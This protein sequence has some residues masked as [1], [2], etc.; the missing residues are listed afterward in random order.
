GISKDNAILVWGAAGVVGLFT[1]VTLLVTLISRR[2][3][4]LTL[5]LLYLAQLGCAALLFISAEAFQRETAGGHVKNLLKKAETLKAEGKLGELNLTLGMQYYALVGGRG[6][7]C[8]SLLLAGLFMHRR[9]WSKLVG[10]MFLSLWPT[11]AVVW[12]FRRSLLGIQMDL[13]FS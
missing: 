3:G 6:T 8:L 5:F 11:L 9:L 4:F 7:A 1:L 2:M 10:F 13:P 12:G